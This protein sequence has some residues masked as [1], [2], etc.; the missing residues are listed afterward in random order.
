MRKITFCLC[1]LFCATLHAAADLF[2]YGETDP[3]GVERIKTQ[4]PSFVHLNGKTIND[5]TAE[6]IQ[7]FRAFLVSKLNS[8]EGDERHMGAAWLMSL[9]DDESVQKVIEAYHAGNHDAG[10]VLEQIAAMPHLMNDVHNG[11]TT[12]K[13]IYDVIIPSIQ[14]QSTRTALYAIMRDKRFPEQT[15]T[16]AERAESLHRQMIHPKEEQAR[17]QLMAWWE[18]NKEAVLA[19]DY[20]KATWLPPADL[21]QIQPEPK[22]GDTP[23]APNH[24]SPSPAPASPLSWPLLAAGALAALGLGWWFVRRAPPGG[25]GK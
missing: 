18:H 10:D 5:L 16:W 9:A 20:A 15:R 6:E 12:W 1:L 21:G 25:G 13:I 2:I 17:T 24:A 7:V 11:P 22:A 14:Y 8:K 23:A 4:N 19:K 3:S